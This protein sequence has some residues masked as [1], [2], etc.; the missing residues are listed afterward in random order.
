MTGWDLFVLCTVFLAIIVL[1][2]AREMRVANARIDILERKGYEIQTELSEIP[3][4]NAR[5]PR[6]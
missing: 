3:D 6:R 1:L 5:T 2:I 4:G